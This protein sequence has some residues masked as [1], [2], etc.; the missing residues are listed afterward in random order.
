MNQWKYTMKETQGTKNQPR[1]QLTNQRAVASRPKLTDHTN[2]QPTNLPPRNQTISKNISQTSYTKTPLQPPTHL[3]Y[4]LTPP[5]TNMEP[6]NGPLEVRRFLLETIISRF[7]VNFWGCNLNYANLHGAKNMSHAASMISWC[8]R[9]LFSFFCHAGRGGGGTWI[10]KGKK[11]W[12]SSKVH[13]WSI[14]LMITN[15]K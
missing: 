12:G 3:F 15:I 6:E 8:S 10:L 13:D 2:K 9:M 5:K 1:N 14:L 4:P 7:H 11:W